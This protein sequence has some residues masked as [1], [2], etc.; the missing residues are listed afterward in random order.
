MIWL[1]SQPLPPFDR[2]H[3]GKREQLTDVRREETVVEEPNHST[4]ES[5]VLHKSF[6]T[7]CHWLRTFREAGGGLEPPP[8]KS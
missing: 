4:A 5:L 7:L 1:L 2:R 3:T 8:Q 6:N